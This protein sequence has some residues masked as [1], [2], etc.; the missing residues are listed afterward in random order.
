M[1]GT[2]VGTGNTTVSKRAK[3]LMSKTLYLDE[4]EEY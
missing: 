2:V 1:P 4:G 3:S